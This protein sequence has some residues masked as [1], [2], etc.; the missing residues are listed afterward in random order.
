M[1]SPSPYNL[2]Q[3]ASAVVI[4]PDADGGVNFYEQVRATMLAQDLGCVGLFRLLFTMPTC[5]MLPTVWK[6]LRSRRG[7]V[8]YTKIYI[9]CKTKGSRH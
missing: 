9:V 2:I 5:K 6:A 8:L 4:L 1:S 3:P 7:S